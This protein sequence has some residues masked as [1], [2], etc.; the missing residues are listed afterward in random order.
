MAVDVGL[1]LISTVPSTPAM[2]TAMLGQEFAEEIFENGLKNHHTDF[3]KEH[4][5]NMIGMVAAG[6]VVMPAKD[7]PITATAK[8]PY[9]KLVQKFS[10][11][12]VTLGFLFTF[13]YLQDLTDILSNEG[14]LLVISSIGLKLGLLLVKSALKEKML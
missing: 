9:Q 12:G 3:V 14:L 10:V 2:W 11:L 5:K 1:A 8:S 13:G 4:V 7:N 6:M